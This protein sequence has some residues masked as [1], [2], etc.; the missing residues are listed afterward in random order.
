[1]K[2]SYKAEKKNR[3]SREFITNECVSMVLKL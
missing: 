2:E 3:L 1:M